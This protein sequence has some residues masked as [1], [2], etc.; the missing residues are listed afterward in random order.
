MSKHTHDRV[1]KKRMNR[2]ILH[3][4]IIYIFIKSTTIISGLTETITE[5]NILS[6]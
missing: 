2:D 6:T 3:N 1:H 5:F 4:V